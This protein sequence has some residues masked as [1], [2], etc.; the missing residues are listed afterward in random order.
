LGGVLHERLEAENMATNSVRAAMEWTNSG[1]II[2][3]HVMHETDSKK[4]FIPDL[5]INEVLHQQLRVV[6][7]IYNCLSALMVINLPGFSIRLLQ[8]SVITLLADC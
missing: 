3:S 8:S 2:L 7:F 5:M 4:F 1:I 6:F